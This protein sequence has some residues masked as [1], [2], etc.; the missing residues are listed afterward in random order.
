M[1][2]ALKPYTEYKDSGAPW[3]GA[4]PAHWAASRLGAVLVERGEN[5]A[6]G[7]MTQVLSVLRDIGVILYEEKGNI[8]NKKSEDI[9]RY[10]IVRPGDIVVNC[11]NV[12][13]GSV[14]LSRYTGCLSPVYYVLKSRSAEDDTA[15][16]NNVFR[17]KP[18][19]RSLVR[20]GNGI[21]AHRMRIPMELLKCEV[22]PRPPRA[23]QKHI[24]RFLSHFDNRINRLIH[25]KRR[26][27]KLL[28]EQKQVII[29]RAVTRGLDPDVRLKASG[30]DWLGD[31]PEHWRVLNLKISTKILRGK[32]THRPRNDPSLYDGPYPFIQTGAVAQ[33]GKLVT[34][35]KQTL[36]DRG[37]AV[38]KMF[39]RGT[40]VMTIAANIGH[41]AILDLDACFPD[42]VVGFIPKIDMDRDFLYYILRSMKGELLREAPVNTQGNLNIDRIGTMSIP[43]APLKEQLKAVLE[44]EEQN[45]HLDAAIFRARR[46]VDLLREYR[47]RLIADVVT[48]KLD[49][50][51]VELPELEEVEALDVD[52]EDD[53][54]DIDE[55]DDLVVEG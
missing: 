26:L 53:L 39:P 43:V 1:T 6:R 38:S 28:D 8:G 30:V 18:F 21:L 29:H 31:V 2:L 11:M 17:L 7:R 34:S 49:V 20:I 48:G 4:I 54:T 22:L 32:F 35:Y 40:L 25:A 33:A 45:Q 27:V 46:E 24:V 42:S 47:T 19:Q 37:L 5:N 44:I 23:E 16:F 51:G 52:A 50:R 41:V 13:I 12:I 15:Y 10:K 9:G 36:N 14:G 3:F 55:D